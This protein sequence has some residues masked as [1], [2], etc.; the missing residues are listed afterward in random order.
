M[1]K[2]DKERSGVVRRSTME[3]YIRVRIEK[4]LGEYLEAARLKYPYPPSMSHIVREALWE[5]CYS[6]KVVPSKEG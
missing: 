3:D 1:K 6:R 2:V 5:Y 4:E